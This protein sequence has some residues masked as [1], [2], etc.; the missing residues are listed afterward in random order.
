MKILIVTETYPPNVKGAALATARLAQELA[1]HG[2]D[3]SV[4]APSTSFKNYKTKKGNL[5]VY[6]LRSI[7]V[8]KKHQFRVSPQP[9]HAREFRE[10]VKEVKPDIMHINNPGFLAQTAISI[11]SQLHI[12]IVGTSHFMPENITHYLHLPDQIEKLLNTSIW[13]IYAKFYEKLNLIISPTQ[14]AADLLKK[15]IVGT[16]VEVISNGIDLKRF[17][18]K[19]DGEYLKKKYKIPQK[20]TLLFVGRLDKEKCLDTFIRAIAIIQDK[21]D[22][23]AVIAGKGKEEKKLRELAE[24]LGV[25]SLIT[26]TGYVPEKDLQNLYKVGDIFVMPSIAELQS[27]VTMEAMA[28]GLPIIGADAV[29]LPHLI[30][31]EQN[32]FLFIPQDENDLADKL[33]RLLQDEKLREKMAAESLHAIKKHDMK[34]TIEKIEKAYTRVIEVYRKNLVKK[35]GKNDVLKR[36]ELNFRKFMPQELSS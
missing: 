14:T 34:K 7:I 29:A 31:N 15:L 2:H 20:P 27:L 18:P 11:S 4:I 28:S 33:L 30:H 21:V 23:H 1:Y 3:I 19:N 12:P 5:T 8:Q 24:E 10:I 22:L 35:P 9:F 32:G 6:R 16:E 17:N 36:I 13:K 25:S 26:F